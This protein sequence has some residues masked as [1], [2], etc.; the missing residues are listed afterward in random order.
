MLIWRPSPLSPFGG[1]TSR[2]T[3]SLSSM[4]RACAITQGGHPLQE[5]ASEIITCR[6]ETSEANVNSRYIKTV[7]R[8]LIQGDYLYLDNDTIAVRPL[9]RDWP[10]GADLAMARDWNK[11]G[12]TAGARSWMT[13]L[14]AEFGWKFFPDRY[15]NGGVMYVRETA[16][17]HAFFGEWH[18]LW[19]QG[20]LLGIWQDQPSLNSALAAGFA[21]FAKLRDRDNWATES[22]RMLRGR[23]RI[24]HF[25]TSAH[26]GETPPG[27][28]L[29][30][31]VTR[32][33]RDGV[34]DEEAMQS[35]T[36]HNFPWMKVSRIKELLAS[37]LYLRAGTLVANRVMRL[38]RR[39]LSR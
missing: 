7:L 36:R 5:I 19:R 32:F 37:G 13:K 21:R 26:G 11:S 3:L 16:A 10:R 30:H 31:L 25:W 39:R 18:R 34:L 6:T 28:L 8:N 14:R 33:Q 38:I 17:A 27:T 24:F 35:A 1:F 9:D 4:S 23:A 29:G 2:R 20:L 12:V 15:Y 22:L